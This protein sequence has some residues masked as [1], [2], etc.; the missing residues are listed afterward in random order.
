MSIQ[1]ERQKVARAQFTDAAYKKKY[2]KDLLSLSLWWD[3]RNSSYVCFQLWSQLIH[4]HFLAVYLYRKIEHKLNRIFSVNPR[5]LRNN[6]EILSF[7]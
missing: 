7:K 1:N 2:G 6:A 4:F 3:L 5:H